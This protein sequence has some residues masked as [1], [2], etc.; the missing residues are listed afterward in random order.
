MCALIT[1]GGGNGWGTRLFGAAVD[2]VVSME[3]VLATQEGCSLTEVDHL[4]NAE[5][6]A[7]LK[8]AGASGIAHMSRQEQY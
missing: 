1:A 4:T 8:G 2:N 3:V 5:L 7:G 6:F